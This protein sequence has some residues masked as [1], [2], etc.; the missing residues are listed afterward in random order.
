MLK[1]I[2]ITEIIF[3]KKKKKNILALNKSGLRK[4][5]IKKE[6]VKYPFGT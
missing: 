5:S 3:K 6:E 2:F 1:N 4:K